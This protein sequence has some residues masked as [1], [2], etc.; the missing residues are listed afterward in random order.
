MDF[1]PKNSSYSLKRA[2]PAGKIRFF[3]SYL[4]IPKLLTRYTIETLTEPFCSEFFFHDELTKRMCILAVNVMNSEGTVV[5]N[6]ATLEVV[7]R[8]VFKMY[9]PSGAG[10]SRWSIAKSIFRDYRF[11]NNTLLHKCFETDWSHTK[12]ER[13]FTNRDERAKV[14]SILGNAYP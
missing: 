6:E 8:P 7:P 3:F 12:L 4:G 1:C 10:A 11:D 9:H 14:K 5:T 13:M 2:V